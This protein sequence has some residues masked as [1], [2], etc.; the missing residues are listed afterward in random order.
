MATE[1]EILVVVGAFPAIPPLLAFFFA[2]VAASETL[3]MAV[4][5][6]PALFL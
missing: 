5:L 6:L 2:I 4:G 3:G 1:S